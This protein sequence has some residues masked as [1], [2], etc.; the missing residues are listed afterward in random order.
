M[1]QAKAVL[2]PLQLCATSLI[3]TII[4]VNLIID[5]LFAP[6]YDVLGILNHTCN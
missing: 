3:S 2:S 5:G 6:D 1:L 4:H